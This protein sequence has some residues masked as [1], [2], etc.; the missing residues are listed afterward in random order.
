MYIAAKVTAGLKYKSV[1]ELSSGQLGS[2]SVGQG[3]GRA[4]LLRRLVASPPWSAALLDGLADSAR[5][6]APHHH[7]RMLAVLDVARQGDELT[8]ATEYVEGVPLAALMQRARERR[9]RV[10]PAAALRIAEELTQAVLAVQEL[11]QQDQPR[12]VFAGIHPETVWISSGD[13]A[14]IAD[15]GL[16][17]FQPPLES[18][19]VAAYRAPEVGR[20][21]QLES[22]AVFSIGVMLWELLTG[23][24]AFGQ[25]EA[26]ATVAGIRNKAIAEAAPRVDALVH[27][28]P[29]LVTEVVMQALRSN[30]AKRFPNVRAFSDALTAVRRKR[31]S[32]EIVHFLNSLASDLLDKQRSSIVKRQVSIESWRPTIAGTDVPSVNIPKAP[33]LMGLAAFVPPSDRQDPPDSGQAVDS[34][35]SRNDGE[36]PM[37][38]E[39]PASAPLSGPR[40]AMPTTPLLLVNKPG[41]PAHGEPAPAPVPPV[42]SVPIATA[43]QPFP[44]Q[45]F[46]NTQIAMR[47]TP[48]T[49]EDDAFEYPVRRRWGLTLFVLFALMGAVAIG[50]LAY[51]KLQEPAESVAPSTA[52]PGTTLDA[53]PQS[54]DATTEVPAASGSASAKRVTPRGVAVPR[55]PRTSASIDG[56]SI[57]DQPDARVAHPDGGA[58]PKSD[59]P[60]ADP[61]PATSV[62]PILGY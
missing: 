54:D 42:G 61:P 49:F 23:R 7:P 27:D 30:P 4:V 47:P 44:N 6:A 20:A 59:N 8:V 28:V 2:M 22:A 13:D 3:T 40:S 53:N 29:A 56:T 60:Y 37:R 50:A 26:G 1:A 58:A 5:R 57:L 31:G 33:R 52:A 11:C 43:A 18:A 36:Q 39:V 48:N 51:M 41:D 19:S 21:P 17:G 24:D 34:L 25:N 62:N 35:L 12:W 55:G 15:L 14:L 38:V 9:I 45:P 10:P 16:V 32:S 46:P